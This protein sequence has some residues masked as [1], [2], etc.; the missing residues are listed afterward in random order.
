MKLQGPYVDVAYAYHEVEN[1]KAILHSC[2]SNIESF[3]SQIYDRAVKIAESVGVE[4]SRPR[5]R[6]W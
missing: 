6:S 2:R 1:V 5:I 4:E 3:H